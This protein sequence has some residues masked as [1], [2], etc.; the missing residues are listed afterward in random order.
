MIGEII[1]VIQVS[2]VPKH[3]QNLFGEISEISG[4][5]L[6]V[7]ERNP[8]GDCLCLCPSGKYLVDIDNRDILAFVEM[9]KSDSMIDIIHEIARKLG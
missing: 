9:P 3:S 2:K 4:V 7:L 6:R 1:G 5:V 8:E